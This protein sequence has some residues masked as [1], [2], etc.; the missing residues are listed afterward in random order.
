MYTR[1]YMLWLF[2]LT[3]DVQSILCIGVLDKGEKEGLCYIVRLSR[4]FEVCSQQ[5][6][7]RQTIAIRES[8]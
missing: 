3:C 8:V 4:N 6:I 2:W 7:E 5:L 1:I